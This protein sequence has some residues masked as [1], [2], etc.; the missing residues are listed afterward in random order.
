M[1]SHDNHTPTHFI[2]PGSLFISKSCLAAFKEDT[3][4]PSQRETYALHARVQLL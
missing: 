2:P 4:S 3:G 1:T